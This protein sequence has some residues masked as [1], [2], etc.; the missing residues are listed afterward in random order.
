[1][2]QADKNK[3]FEGLKYHE[4]L[5]SN[6]FLKH[7]EIKK[8]CPFLFNERKISKFFVEDLKNWL[9]DPD[10]SELEKKPLEI[11]PNTKQNE[12]I[13]KRTESGFRRI[14]GPA[15]SGKSLVI[16]ARAAELVILDKSVLII[17][18]NVTLINYLKGLFFRYLRFNLQSKI[19]S[20]KVTFIHYHGFCKRRLGHLE[21]YREFWKLLKDDSNAENKDVKMRA[22]FDEKIPNLLIAAGST[23]YSEIYDAILVDEGQDFIPKWWESL[24]KFKT[25]TEKRYFVQTILKIFMISLVH[26]QPKL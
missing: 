22:I 24:L 21:G 11:L 16:A 15:G 13:K 3:G 2:A 26:G 20:P 8:E 17:T 14:I 6:E 18:Y 10:F 1:M 9:L 4:V 5:N 19:Q 25:K 7:D 23:C 12:V